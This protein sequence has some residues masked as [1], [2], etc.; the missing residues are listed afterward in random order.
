MESLELAGRRIREDAA[1]LIFFPEG[2]RSATGELR[3]F[4]KG[5]FVLAI[6]TGVPVVPCAVVGGRDVMPKGSWRIRTGRTIR[7]RLGNPIPVDGLGADDRNA[8]TVRARG[9]VRELLEGGAYG[10]PHQL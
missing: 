4:K 10:D 8:L 1:T 7:V 2:T 6:Q 9:A 5:A 3:P